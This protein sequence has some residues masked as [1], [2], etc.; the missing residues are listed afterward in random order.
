MINAYCVDEIIVWKWEA[1]DSWG[2][3]VSGTLIDLKGY[4]EWKTRLLRGLRGE[5]V[6]SSCSVRLPKRKLDALLGRTLSHKDKLQIGGES[7]ERAIV[8]I[9]TPKAFTP[10][11]NKFN[12]DYEVFLA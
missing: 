10:N 5:E 7:F 8:L 11:V 6:F 12:I 2:D 9:T 4:V 3:P 1:D